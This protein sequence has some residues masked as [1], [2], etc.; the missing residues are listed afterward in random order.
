[1]NATK[2]SITLPFVAFGLRLFAGIY[3]GVINGFA[4]SVAVN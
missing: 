1:M 3:I 2:G 4:F